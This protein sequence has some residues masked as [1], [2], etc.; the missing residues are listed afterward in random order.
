M[1]GAV[2]TGGTDMI[3]AYTATTRIEG[4]A[5]SFGDSGASAISVLVAQNRGAEKEDRVWETYRSGLVLMLAVGA[6]MSLIMYVSAG[7]TVGFMLG[8]FGGAAFE[9]ARSY[10]RLVAVFYV[11]CFTGNVFAGYFDGIGRV[12]IPFV[13]A[14]THITLRVILSWLLVGRM[15]LRAVAL[16]TGLGWILVNLMWTVIKRRLD[17]RAAERQTAEPS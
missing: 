14:T 3:A 13:G 1:Q 6:L 10:M 5:N 8:V 16:A 9:N 2:N 7:A 12:S 15:G 17:R 4:F 11:L